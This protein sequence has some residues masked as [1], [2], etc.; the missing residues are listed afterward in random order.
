MPQCPVGCCTRR[1]SGFYWQTLSGAAR[2]LHSHV[3]TVFCIT[4]TSLVHPQL[5]WGFGTVEPGAVMGLF[6]LCNS[7]EPEKQLASGRG[8]KS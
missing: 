7:S 5:D 3:G 1:R 6:S 8:E 4:V 2:N